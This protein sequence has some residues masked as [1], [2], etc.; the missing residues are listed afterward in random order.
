M[1]PMPQGC[2]SHHAAVGLTLRLDPGNQAAGIIEYGFVLVQGV[3]PRADD[4]KSPRHPFFNRLQR[5]IIS[6]KKCP[7]IERL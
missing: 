2:S 7:K 5:R 3:W 1:P 4:G 6:L